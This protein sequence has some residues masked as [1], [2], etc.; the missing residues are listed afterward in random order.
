MNRQA[1]RITLILWLFWTGLKIVR[2]NDYFAA[3]I[4]PHLVGL[5]C[6]LIASASNPYLPTFEGIWSI[7]LPVAVINA[8]LLEQ[9]GVTATGRA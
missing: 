9:G 1:T 2:S 8:W 7:F 5:C 3:L 4:T 6:F